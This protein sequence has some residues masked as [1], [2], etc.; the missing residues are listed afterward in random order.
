[1]D[2]ASV[3]NRGAEEDLERT[4]VEGI[5]P[6]ERFRSAPIYSTNSLA[7]PRQIPV[8]V[9]KLA[10]GAGVLVF[11]SSDLFYLLGPSLKS[12]TVAAVRELIKKEAK[13]IP[14]LI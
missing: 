1:M 2:Q 14:T 6:L 10:E 5:R 3:G 7:S 12:H 11:A 13:T 4:L 8:T 9:R